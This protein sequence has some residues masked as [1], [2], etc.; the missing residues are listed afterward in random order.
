MSNS[1]SDDSLFD[2]KWGVLKNPGFMA[3]LVLTPG[4]FITA[5][6]DDLNAM[7]ESVIKDNLFEKN[8]TDAK[9][10]SDDAMRVIVKAF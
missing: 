10:A 1:N 9:D 3:S 7:D 6:C 8:F 4:S 5:D 2:V